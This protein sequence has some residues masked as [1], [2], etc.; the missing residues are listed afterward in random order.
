MRVLKS[1]DIRSLNN[2]VNVLAF[3]R[4]GGEYALI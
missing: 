2:Q 3:S 1:L 4:V